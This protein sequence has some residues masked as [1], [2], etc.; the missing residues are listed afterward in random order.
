MPIIKT[1]KG[2]YKFGQSGKEYPTKKQALTQ[3]RA[4]KASQSNS[5]DGNK[6]K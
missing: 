3:M 1:S 2:T 6:T 5:K 4:I